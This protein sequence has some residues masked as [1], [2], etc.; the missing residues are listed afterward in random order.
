LPSTLDWTRPW[1]APWRPWGEPVTVALAH[2]LPLHEALNAQGLA[3]VTFVPQ[4]ALPS[5]VAYETFIYT[6][7]QCPVR[8][9]LHD[10]FNGLCWMRFAALK[11]QLNCWQAQAITAAITTAISGAPRG[12]VRDAITVF[13]ENAAFLDAPA[14][15]WQA[16]QAKDWQA[17]FITHRALWDEARITLFGHALLEKLAKP[18]KGMVAHVFKPFDAIK[19]ITENLYRNCEER[20][21][22]PLNFSPEILATKPFAPLPVLGVP[23]WWA[24]NEEPGFYGDARVFRAPAEAK[25]F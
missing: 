17:L 9:G 6:T 7:R 21:F 11:L 16:L 10:F 15:L 5:G 2:G 23:G 8:T 14:A 12:P 13:D 4:S 3:P 19:N 1:Y 24:Q 20:D 25:S 22:L 18:R